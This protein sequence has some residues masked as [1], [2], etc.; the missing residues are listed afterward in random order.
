M[1]NINF[2][3]WQ[4]LNLRTGEIIKVEDVEE[5]NKLYKLK[6]D[7]GTETRTLVAGLKPYYQKEELEGKRCVVFTNL[8]PKKI[9]GIESKGMILAAVSD[10]HNNVKLL[11]PDG[12]IEV[13]S[14]I[15]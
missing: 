2:N 6:V 9:R 4:K 7:L 5:A 10:D 13:G 14:K 3:Q 1:E 12:L 8:E 15:S 11:Q